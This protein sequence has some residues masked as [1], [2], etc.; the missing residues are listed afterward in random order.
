MFV[1]ALNCVDTKPDLCHLLFAC[2]AEFICA[3]KSFLHD[4]DLKHSIFTLN[5]DQEFNQEGF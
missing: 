2:S 4:F 3:H 1:V 5:M